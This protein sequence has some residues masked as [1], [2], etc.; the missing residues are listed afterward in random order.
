MELNPP[1]AR[2]LDSRIED[3]TR[4][5]LHIAPFGG[6]TFLITEVPALLAGKSSKS[7]V[8]DIADELATRERS[9]S[10][11]EAVDHVVATMACHSVVRA[12]EKIEIREVRALLEKMDT[13]DFAATCPHGRPV[14]TI[15]PFSEI[16]KRMRRT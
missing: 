1:E 16:E 2:A 11:E 8:E 6:D 14:Y 13:I 9:S 10:F 5:G 15:I 12:G 3:L 7:L 4:L